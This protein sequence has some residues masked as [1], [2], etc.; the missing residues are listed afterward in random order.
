LLIRK[1]TAKKRAFFILFSIT[2]ASKG[3]KNRFLGFFAHG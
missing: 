3:L 1:K 2:W